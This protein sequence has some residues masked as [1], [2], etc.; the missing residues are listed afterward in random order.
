MSFEEQLMSANKYP[1]ICS[2]QMEA[3]VF[4][5]LQIF[6]AT[7][8]VLKI[9][10]IDIRGSCVPNVQS[11]GV[12]LPDYIEGWE[13]LH[14]ARV[15]GR[16]SHSLQNYFTC[17]K[18]FTCT[19]KIFHTCECEGAPKK[20]T[21]T[22]KLFHMCVKKFTCNAKLFHICETKFEMHYMKFTPIEKC[23]HSWQYFSHAF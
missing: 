8:A 2:P 18:C 11:G 7:R 15:H 10:D 13:P 4:I 14:E 6:C 20:L 3:I 21:Y 23:S 9:G 22:T 1:S 5:I 12:Y 19:T 17:V 16:K